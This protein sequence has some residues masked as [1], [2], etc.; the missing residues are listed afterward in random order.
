VF[1]VEPREDC[2]LAARH[3]EI[4]DEHVHIESEDAAKQQAARYEEILA[5]SVVAAA[6]IPPDVLDLLRRF[7]V[8][9]DGSTLTVMLEV[10]GDA[11]AQTRALSTL[12]SI[13]RA[14]Q[15]AEARFC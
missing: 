5:K 13:A 6:K 10:S 9:V 1:L 2:F 15:S 14:I 7:D 11:Q 12:M 4:R 3:G 8:C